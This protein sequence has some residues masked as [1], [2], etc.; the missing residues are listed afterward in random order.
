MDLWCKRLVIAVLKRSFLLWIKATL[1]LY[2][3]MQKTTSLD[4]EENDN[5]DLGITN[6]STSFRNDLTTVMSE[7]ISVHKF[8][9]TEDNSFVDILD[10]TEERENSTELFIPGIGN[11]E[12]VVEQED[13]IG[14]IHSPEAQVDEEVQVKEMMSNE[15]THPER[16]QTPE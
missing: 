3:L 7:D 2:S 16:M 5:D 12:E 4:E 1:R 13:A 8:V 9:A 6:D 10:N 11:K 15:D 14:Y